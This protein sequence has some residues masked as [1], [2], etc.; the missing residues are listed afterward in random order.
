MPRLQQASR[1]I[2]RT[3]DLELQQSENIACKKCIAEYEAD[4]LDNL[5]DLERRSSKNA[6]YCI[7]PVMI[8]SQP[9]LEWYMRP[10]LIDFLLE[11]HAYFRLRPETLFLACS[12]VDR[13]LS[14]RMVRK[15]HYQL[16]VS[17]AL[18]IAAKYEDKKSRT[19]LLKELV[20]LCR[21]VYEAKMFVQMEMHILSTLDWSI[22][23]VASSYDCLA[24]FLDMECFEKDPAA[25]SIAQLAYFLLEHS[26][27]ERNYLQHSCTIRALSAALVASKMMESSNLA[28]QIHLGM[29]ASPDPLFQSALRKSNALNALP[30]TTETLQDVRKC[31]LLFVNDIFGTKLLPK[32]FS[33][34][35]L[36][37]YR[38]SS[39]EPIV[40]RYWS[41]HI[42][43]YTSFCQLTQ[44]LNA[45]DREHVDE[46][47]EN[48]I[49]SF[50]G[51]RCLRKNNSAHFPEPYKAAYWSSRSSSEHSAHIDLTDC[52][53][54]WPSSPYASHPPTTA[55]LSDSESTTPYTPLSSSGSIFSS[56]FSNLSQSSAGSPML[57]HT[58][59][60]LMTRWTSHSHGYN[61]TQRV[62][63]RLNSVESSLME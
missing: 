6:K 59:K 42:S 62:L 12:I 4:F 39:V 3:A 15:A 1:G 19:P 2:I 51:L 57:S 43:Q 48:F 26:M 55:N 38:G 44:N 33:A 11:L 35:L 45:I 41:Q 37:K 21:N 56:S 49:E 53:G 23:C 18:W 22:G 24:L 14:K 52:P 9:E 7:D 54:G 30:L 20:H 10:Y 8:D 16:T 29:F 47:V 61:N 5:Q 28:D 40:D 25:S 31:G 60:P 63:T 13:Y 34:A 50:V 17:T 46:T 32:P 58:G 27:Y 36:Q